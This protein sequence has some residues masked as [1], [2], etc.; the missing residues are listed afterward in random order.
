MGFAILHG[1][2]LRRLITEMSTYA[3]PGT[4]MAQRRPQEAVPLYENNALCVVAAPASGKEHFPFSTFFYFFFLFHGKRKMLFSW[5]GRSEVVSPA[6]NSSQP[7]EYKPNR[8]FVTPSTPLQGNEMER[9]EKER[10]GAGNTRPRWPSDCYL[11]L[12][13]NQRMIWLFHHNWGPHQS[14]QK[15]LQRGKRIPLCKAAGFTIAF[16]GSE[17]QG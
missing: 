16:R 7:L 17:W 10:L 13:M 5:C 4:Q 15:L 9:R 3:R 11:Q 2:P 6:G 1:E 12:Q 8:Q 14:S